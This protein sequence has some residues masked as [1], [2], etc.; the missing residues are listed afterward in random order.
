LGKSNK[1]EGSTTGDLKNST[2]TKHEKQSNNTRNNRHNTMGVTKQNYRKA[3]A[4]TVGTT[5]QKPLYKRYKKIDSIFLSPIATNNMVQ[6]YQ[7]PEEQQQVTMTITE[8]ER[9]KREAQLEVLRETVRA[10]LDDV[11]RRMVQFY[12]KSILS[13]TL[14]V[15]S[16][17][18]A[19][20]WLGDPH[21]TTTEW[22]PDRDC[23]GRGHKDIVLQW[24][25]QEGEVGTIP[26]S[27]HNWHHLTTC[28]K[29]GPK[30]KLYFRIINI[31]FNYNID[32]KTMAAAFDYITLAKL[33]SPLSNGKMGI[34]WETVA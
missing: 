2:Q 29:T 27:Y 21:S 33:R 1:I 22:R 7:S 12:S 13:Q 11:N 26:L 19:F 28:E 14:G 20:L 3:K 15:M 31:T 10:M 8:L 24:H 6:W 34:V 25:F 16:R 23:D 4:N 9:I 32:T 30:R 5:T 17:N 18:H